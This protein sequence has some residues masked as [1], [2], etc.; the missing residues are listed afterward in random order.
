MRKSNDVK[1]MKKKIECP[2]SSFYL[3]PHTDFLILVNY[4]SKY[5]KIKKK[6][7]RRIITFTSSC[8]TQFII[9]ITNVK[10]FII[11]LLELFYLSFINYFFYYYNV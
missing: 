8:Q 10:H 7:K 11:G 4:S 9:N 3:I 5:S 1:E 2:Y 6:N